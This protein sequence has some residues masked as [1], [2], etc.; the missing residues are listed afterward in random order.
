MTLQLRM[1]LF[2][3]SEEARAEDTDDYSSPADQRFHFSVTSEF[4]LRGY[5][6]YASKDIYLE[7]GD[8][9]SISDFVREDGVWEVES[10]T[11]NPGSDDQISLTPIKL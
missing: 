5:N 9:L 11:L 10:V 7:K 8:N 6:D 3:V 1:M 2:V 4:K